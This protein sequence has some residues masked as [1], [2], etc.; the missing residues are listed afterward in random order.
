MTISILT[1]VLF[2]LLASVLGGLG[3]VILGLRW[4][5][6]SSVKDKMENMAA[7]IGVDKEGNVALIVCDGIIVPHVQIVDLNKLLNDDEEAGDFEH[8]DEF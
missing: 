7:T 5:I 3:G 2:L 1:L 6:E 4:K 8:D